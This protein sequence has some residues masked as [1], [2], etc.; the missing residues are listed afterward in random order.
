MDLMCEAAQFHVSRVLTGLDVVLNEVILISL[1]Q[2]NLLSSKV[3]IILQ[4]LRHHSSLLI[5]RILFD[6]STM[7]SSNVIF[8]YNFFSVSLSH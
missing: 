8:R 6:P 3:V 2:L 7:L 5:R 1:F 4:S